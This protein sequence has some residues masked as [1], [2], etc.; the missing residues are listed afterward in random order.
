MAWVAQLQNDDI[1][2]DRD[3]PLARRD[4]PEQLRPYAN[5]A[6]PI[7]VQALDDP[8]KFAA[9]HILLMCAGGWGNDGDRAYWSCRS[10]VYHILRYKPNADGTATYDPSQIPQLKEMWSRA[11]IEPA[12][13]VS[14]PDSRWLMIVPALFLAV[15]L[16]RR[17]ARSRPVRVGYCSR[18]GY[19]LRASIARCPECGEPIPHP[20][21][22]LQ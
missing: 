13:S 11:L 15:F 3:S 5:R 8:R 4:P 19:D 16:F 6:Y 22:P 17:I 20:F 7:L 9:A 2:W 21:T 10:G 18:C 12:A 14:M 1:Y